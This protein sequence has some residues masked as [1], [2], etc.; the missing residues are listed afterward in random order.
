MYMEKRKFSIKKG[1]FLISLLLL[2]ACSHKTTNM[3]R[4][5]K[6]IYSYSELLDVKIELLSVKDTKPFPDFLSTNVESTVF[7]CL[8]IKNV[9]NSAI[10]VRFHEPY[11]EYVF[12]PS[13][14]LGG[15]CGVNLGRNSSIMAY[16]FVLIQPSEEIS[17]TVVYL[18]CNKYQGLLSVY[19]R[20]I[21]L[22]ENNENLVRD[23]DSI[24]SNQ[25]YISLE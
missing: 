11:L 9:H 1:G 25:V 4:D 2:I 18:N 7:M 24:C 15:N 20:D 6:Q 21:I 8:K 22:N 3:H 17:D 23:I 16:N 14:N 19:Y 12:R 10:Q 5:F 13:I